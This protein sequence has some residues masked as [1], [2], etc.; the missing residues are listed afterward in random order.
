[1]WE[2]EQHWNVSWS[3]ET[4]WG[5]SFSNGKYFDNELDARDFFTKLSLK[6]EVDFINLEKSIV[7]RK[8]NDKI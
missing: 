5:A 3:G 8:V 1:M 6:D 4:I 7:W 2:K